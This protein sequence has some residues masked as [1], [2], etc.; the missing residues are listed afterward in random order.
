VK[1]LFTKAAKSHRQTALSGNVVVMPQDSGLVAGDGRPFRLDTLPKFFKIIF[2]GDRGMLADLQRQLKAQAKYK[3]PI[4][5]ELPVVRRDV[6]REFIHFRRHYRLATAS[7]RCFTAP[8]STSEWQKYFKSLPA[9]GIPEPLVD[10]ATWL[11][12]ESVAEE[13]ARAAGYAASESAQ[14]VTG[15][16]TAAP[17][18]VSSHPCPACACT[19]SLAQQ[20]PGGRPRHTC[21]ATV[22]GDGVTGSQPEPEPSD[23]KP[24]A[25]S[26]FVEGAAMAV[27]ACEGAELD[28]FEWDELE[29]NLCDLVQRL[30][31]AEMDGE[32][33][34]WLVRFG[35]G[36]EGQ[37][38]VGAAYGRTEGVHR[39]QYC[40]NP[41]D[42]AA[43]WIDM[44]I[45]PRLLLDIRTTG[46][47]DVDSSSLSQQ[48]M[49]T[50][51]CA[52]LAKTKAGDDIYIHTRRDTLLS[53]LQDP[54]MWEALLPT[55]YVTG[56]GGP[57]TESEKVAAQRG[58]T[59]PRARRQTVSSFEA[60][61]NRQLRHYTGAFDAHPH[62]NAIVRS[63]ITRK[64]I[65]DSIRIRGRRTGRPGEM[66]ARVK[67]LEQ[68]VRDG[69][70]PRPGS[71]IAKL[72]KQFE[73]IGSAVEGSPWHRKARRANLY[74]L[75]LEDGAGCLFVT[76]N[77]APYQDMRVSV[78]GE[79]PMFHAVRM[80][81]EG[82][83]ATTDSRLQT[84][85]SRP[86]L[87]ARYAA[88]FF[89][90]Y[91]RALIGW[92]ENEQGVPAQLPHEVRGLFGR[93][94]SFG[95][96]IESQQRGTLHGHATLHVCDMGVQ[97]LRT[98]LQ[99]PA[100]RQ[101]LFGFLD[102]V[103]DC[104][105]PPRVKAFH[106]SV[107]GAS[108]GD[109]A[110][111]MADYRPKEYPLTQAWC[112]SCPPI[113]P[114]AATPD[115]RPLPPPD[116][117]HRRFY[118]SPAA[119]DAEMGMR[120]ALSVA[121][122]ASCYHSHYAGCRISSDGVIVCVARFPRAC[123]S[124][125]ERVARAQGVPVAG[126][127]TRLAVVVGIVRPVAL[128]SAI[129]DASGRWAEALPPVGTWAEVEA[130]CGETGLEAKW[131]ATYCRE[132][133]A[134]AGD[135]ASVVLAI[136]ASHILQLNEGII[137]ETLTAR[138]WDTFAPRVRT[139]LLTLHG[140][141]F[142][143][144]DAE[145]CQKRW[146]SAGSGRQ[147]DAVADVDTWREF[148]YSYCAN[149][150][151]RVS[152][153]DKRDS[154]WRVPT[155]PAVSTVLPFNAS[156][157]VL[158]DGIL[159]SHKAHYSTNYST[160]LG[161]TDTI[162]RIL[163]LASLQKQIV[164]PDAEDLD[165]GQEFRR[166]VSA[167]L[168]AIMGKMSF[169]GQV[170][171]TYTLGERDFYASHEFVD[172]HYFHYFPM[173]SYADADAEAGAAAGVDGG[174]MV[175][176]GQS[177]DGDGSPDDGPPAD[178]DGPG[179]DD[180]LEDGSTSDE[181]GAQDSGEGQ[182]E[183]GSPSQL[184]DGPAARARKCRRHAPPSADGD[185]ATLSDVTAGIAANLDGDDSAPGVEGVD[186]GAADAGA[187]VSGTWVRAGDTFVLSAR[188]AAYRDRCAPTAVLPDSVLWAPT[189]HGDDGFGHL[190]RMGVIDYHL[191][192][193]DTQQS[194]K[195][196]RPYYVE[197]GRESCIA[198]GH[199]QVPV[200][201]RHKP[202][203]RPEHSLT[204]VVQPRHWR[205]LWQCLLRQYP[206][207]CSMAGHFAR[208][209][210]CACFDEGAEGADSASDVRATVKKKV[211]KMLRGMRQADV[212]ALEKYCLF[213]RTF[214]SPHASVPPAFRD[215]G[216]G[217]W[218]CEFAVAYL[219]WHRHHCLVWPGQTLHF[220]FNN[221]G[222]SVDDLD[223]VQ[224]G[225]LIVTSG[226]R[227]G[228][229]RESDDGAIGYDKLVSE[230][231]GH[232]L[233]FKT[234][235]F[236][237]VSAAELCG[238]VRDWEFDLR[239][240]KAD[241]L[242]LGRQLSFRAFR[243]WLTDELYEAGIDV[244]LV[245][246]VVQDDDLNNDVL[247]DLLLR[248]PHGDDCAD[249]KPRA[250]GRSG[251]RRTAVRGRF[252]AA[253][254]NA[255][256]SQDRTTTPR[257]IQLRRSVAERVQRLR[258]PPKGRVVAVIDAAAA[259]RARGQSD[260][261]PDCP[262]SYWLAVTQ[263][264]VT[265]EQW[266]GRERFDVRYLEDPTPVDVDGQ[267][268]HWK[269]LSDSTDDTAVPRENVLCQLP[270]LDQ[271]VRDGAE[272]HVNADLHQRCCDAAARHAPVR[273]RVSEFTDASVV[274]TE[275][276]GEYEVRCIE[277][278]DVTP[279]ALRSQEVCSKALCGAR[280]TL[281]VLGV[282]TQQ[283]PFNHPRPEQPAVLT[284]PGGARAR[285]TL[286]A[287]ARLNAGN[288]IS[289]E[290]ALG[291]GSH[292]YRNLR[293][294]GNIHGLNGAGAKRAE[295][296]RIEQNDFDL[297]AQGLEAAPM[298]YLCRDRDQIGD[299]IDEAQVEYAIAASAKQLIAIG[300]G[301]LA[302]RI[303]PLTLRALSGLNAAF[304]ALCM[305]GGVASDDQRGLREGDDNG[306]SDGPATADD[307]GASITASI[308]C[309]RSAT[310]VEAIR[311][312][313]AQFRTQLK[314]HNL[315]ARTS[316]QSAAPSPEPHTAASHPPAPPPP[317]LTPL[318]P[319]DD[320]AVAP[321]LTAQRASFPLTLR[322]TLASGAPNHEVGTP[323]GKP[324]NPKQAEAIMCILSLLG[325]KGEPA[326][327]GTVGTRPPP[328]S[329]AVFDGVDPLYFVIGEP[330]T[331]KSVVSDAVR[332]HIESHGRTHDNYRVLAAMGKAAA[333][334]H[335]STFD[336]FRAQ[337]GGHAAPPE[338]Q[339]RAARR[340]PGIQPV[341]DA[342]QKKRC[343][344][345]FGRLELIIVD[346]YE[347]LKLESFGV[348]KAILEAAK[349]NDRPWGGV[350]VVIIGDPF[351]L[352]SIGGASVY[353][354]AASLVQQPGQTPADAWEQL[355]SDLH[356]KHGAN[357]WK[358]IL[359]YKHSYNQGGWIA[360]RMFQRGVILT[361]QMRAQ[362]EL[363]AIL[364]RVRWAYSRDADGRPFERNRDAR[365]K[366]RGRDPHRGK[367]S[368]D[369]TRKRETLIANDAKRLRRLRLSVRNK[370]EL[371][372]HDFASAPVVSP[373]NEPR[374]AVI[375]Q[376]VKAWGRAN[377]QRIVRWCA[378]DHVRTHP[379]NEREKDS[380][381]FDKYEVHGKGRGAQAVAKLQNYFGMKV[382]KNKQVEADQ[383]RSAKV[384]LHFWYGYGLP[385]VLNH[386]QACHC[387]WTN[388]TTGSARSLVVDRREPPDPDPQSLE[389]EF[390][391]LQYEPVC[392]A[393]EPDK[394]MFQAPDTSA[395][396][397]S[398]NHL[399]LEPEV[400]EFK[401]QYSRKSDDTLPIWRRNFV[402]SPALCFTEYKVIGS[403]LK[404]VIVH[405][406]DP[407]LMPNAK[408]TYNLQ[409]K[410]VLLSRTRE[411][412][413]VAFLCE[414]DYDF[415]EFLR[416]LDVPAVRPPPCL[417]AVMHVN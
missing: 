338:G 47:I 228:I 344:N 355:V 320:A 70:K 341:F 67:D 404:S 417:I 372:K 136:V 72:H 189:P 413:A 19:D 330:G 397:W 325:F 237:Q 416:S 37:L 252:V 48:D 116:P 113:G 346:E 159:A 409:Q 111:K 379:K 373:L 41:A 167:S 87:S 24:A 244:Q 90:G 352:G 205:G 134:S 315:Q 76:I 4:D 345:A 270:E 93:V 180:E 191:T 298:G 77:L 321:Q 30:D 11:T 380:T 240:S 105:H 170:M 129:G 79:E 231:G 109:G 158:A 125:A 248:A 230:V 285:G 51:A 57:G 101:R 154:H 185:S 119:W 44:Y 289:F 149:S 156:V 402:V 216:P 360:L 112:E 235:G 176:Y 318:P 147:R 295:R 135:S 367:Y 371:L 98:R 9:C 108:G 92:M 393:L 182:P 268:R 31:V 262:V 257:T 168:I 38:R 49:M 308:V 144:V 389:S 331:G 133:L 410:L 316:A 165:G 293:R 314:K 84:I 329:S 211:R 332:R 359:N 348:L 282:T 132:E 269:Y 148:A 65:F 174:G 220:T 80:W 103:V 297:K 322:Q 15:P 260:D 102:T 287:S 266:L 225:D 118:S 386:N 223:T 392:F 2:A 115:I 209:Y 369:A 399:V 173:W 33:S 21:N 324:V 25:A 86:A 406:P 339:K 1:Y 107:N 95:M 81:R 281:R 121:H 398:A 143:F 276:T 381:V 184:D 122:K 201:V 333:N 350:T 212:K 68:L 140:A 151:P 62:Y 363:G 253:A 52:K 306:D 200:S 10:A 8:L 54:R 28:E 97:W 63:F 152:L 319:D 247:A 217:H 78:A 326:A 291:R 403:T 155:N 197:P 340:P 259:R 18:A 171:A 376:R 277:D 224:I 175:K 56:L 311:Q 195:L 412:D 284:L 388:G 383:R 42:A 157:E 3:Q 232:R 40:R 357:S 385:M 71:D 110:T 278:D 61:S 75:A 127:A 73:V 88:R 364:K 375:E 387:G 194:Q 172:I 74:G 219:Q 34:M 370:Q 187:S 153:V 94:K 43:A 354:G 12:P 69:G 13:R 342:S 243:R 233:R 23:D 45:W 343:R 274:M 60:D 334:V 347:M 414:D 337:V 89:Q 290:H 394:P 29:W 164:K 336:S 39:G 362:G 254:G 267:P 161:I 238:H 14:A 199:V 6:V 55:L 401:W 58:H 390:W 313:L 114:F 59:A 349:G 142:E 7:R 206:K 292:A 411:L 146:E 130:I 85:A 382:K 137:P 299:L 50:A 317:P 179:T 366:K 198:P 400:A 190:H 405:I 229:V 302:P 208:G 335:G 303:S 169:P 384:P 66:K 210:A 166:M 391:E 251:R 16:A 258:A 246:A 286:R 26:A 271:S 46:L 280:L 22:R 353:G 374:N 305:G 138:D 239:R 327:A 139:T 204:S 249:L 263:H 304:S 213:W 222:A 226:N 207:P 250:V 368:A 408:K 279:L 183:S 236:E 193:R 214:L 365:L 188:G 186:D 361:D 323:F 128:E 53:G 106:T 123:F 17:Q 96:P 234:S 163:M 162:I 141:D 202:S 310:D 396:A 178:L 312:D 283:W 261:V 32:S 203:I 196:S 275:L 356:R 218:V 415:S 221:G 150:D 120:L 377:G 192:V 64:H 328:S 307:G 272:V 241:L 395:S 126:Q 378:S 301:D 124:E 36:E 177:G 242:R 35:D 20:P 82:T 288:S 309:P 215:V 91:I 256:N 265:T 227:L 5:R 181:G 117:S 83:F 27:M 145:W 273:L 104:N 99:D 358:T 294:V 131:V 255:R 351:Q 296:E 100:A 407:S 245:K 160:K 300:S 264:A